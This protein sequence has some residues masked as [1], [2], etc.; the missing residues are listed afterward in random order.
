MTHISFVVIA[1]NEEATI[2]RALESIRRQVGLDDYEVIVVDD[3]SS[4]GTAA[5]VERCR[6]ADPRIR[7][8]SL[9]R[10]EGRGHAR[11]AGVEAASGR[12][13]AMVDADIVLPAGWLER[14]REAL[15]DA[16]AV[17]G[18]AVP[19]GDVAYIGRRFGLAPRV[20][21][22]TVDATGSNT[23]FRRAVFA[24]V[25]FD[26]ALRNGEDIALA[27]AMRRRGIRVRTVSGLIVRHE[28]AKGFAESLRWL[29]E[30]GIGATRQLR[31]FGEPRTPDLAFVGFLAAVAAG[32]TTWLRGRRPAAVA[33]PVVVLVAT[34]AL[35]L[36]TK[37]WLRASPGASAAA[38]A[39]NA[40]LIAAY[41]AGRLAGLAKTRDGRTV[42]ERPLAR[43]CTPR[44]AGDR[45]ASPPPRTRREAETA[46]RPPRS[47]RAVPS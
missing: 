15:R 14:C 36:R 2:E 47:S 32:L 5:A 20:A 41:F 45:A 43:P 17:A 8:M 10:N 38:V 13:I 28:E 27:H 44:A 26:R 9:L 40:A 1:Y 16:D 42:R 4:D 30:S 18:I 39:V 12:Y 24:Q 21:A 34:S 37:F 25:G 6:D 35:H 23:L 19:D 31:R 46:G 33:A 22:H 11:A 29:F 7:L 3:G